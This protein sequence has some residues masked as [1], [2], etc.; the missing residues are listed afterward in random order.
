[1]QRKASRKTKLRSLSFFLASEIGM[2]AFVGPVGDFVKT[3]M[4]RGLVSVLKNWT[5]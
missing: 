4:G 3:A 2:A 1:M 5:Q